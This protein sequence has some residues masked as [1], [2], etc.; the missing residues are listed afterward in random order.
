MAW[1]TGALVALPEDLCAVSSTHVRL[2]TTIYSSSSR[3]SKTFLGTY[4][5]VHIPICVC[6]CRER[7]RDSPHQL[8][9]RTTTCAPCVCL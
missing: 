1:K 6:V 4:I 8:R 5:L 3:G 9:N 2:L 7:E